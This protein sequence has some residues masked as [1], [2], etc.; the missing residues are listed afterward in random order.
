MESSFSLTSTDNS[1]TEVLEA[2][3][4]ERIPLRPPLITSDHD[5][6]T[7]F[8]RYNQ[9]AIQAGFSIKKG[10][11]GQGHRVSYWLCTLGPA[12]TSTKTQKRSRLTECPFQLKV[13]RDA[14]LI[15]RT[16]VIRG[17][18]NHGS[19][20]EHNNSLPEE[21]NTLY[22]VPRSQTFGYHT[23]RNRAR[24]LQ[25]AVGVPGAMTHIW[26][27]NPIHELALHTDSH[28]TIS[29]PSFTIPP[30]L[31]A[32]RTEQPDKPTEVE[33]QAQAEADEE[34]ALAR[35]EDRLR[36]EE[37][38]RFLQECQNNLCPECGCDMGPREG[39]MWRSRAGGDNFRAIRFSERRR[40]CSSHQERMN[41]ARWEALG[42]PLKD[43]RPVLDNRWRTRYPRCII[44]L[45][46][47]LRSRRQQSQLPWLQEFATLLYERCSDGNRG[48][49]R[50]YNELCNNECMA[51]TKPGLGYY[52]TEFAIEL[53]IL[54][55]DITL[56]RFQEMPVLQDVPGI[57]AFSP[58]Q[59]RDMLLDYVVYPELVTRFV[60]DDFGLQ[61]IEDGVRKV[62]E[63]NHL[64]NVISY[65]HNS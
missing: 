53:S 34:L 7:L 50:I 12:T 65:S 19:L 21:H 45:C 14:S 30:G 63:T 62:K 24:K 58:N 57:N 33:L 39:Q 11:R 13:E 64:S 22:Q 37:H 16:K 3:S 8:S 2:I 42:L 60:M 44:R 49:N 29:P 4:G 47:D 59:M 17:F 6:E 25:A 27:I 23:R 38:E 15:Y 51:T 5:Y 36:N 32:E 18:H 1:A 31:P 20:F 28:T 55:R 56:P 41:V 10:H 43:G 48:R 26:A 35:A 46:R 54:T 61:L 40:L 9:A 52:G